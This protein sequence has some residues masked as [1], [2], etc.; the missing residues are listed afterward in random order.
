MAAARQSQADGAAT[1]D[2]PGNLQTPSIAEIARIFPDL[3]IL[4]LIGRGGMGAVYKVRQKNLDRIV[5]LKVFLYRPHDVEF[6][7]RFQREARALA[8]LNHP[9]IVTVHDFGIRENTHFLIMEYVDGLNLRQLTSEERLP[10]EM[11]LQ[12][13]PQL[14]D[15]LQYAHDHG[16]IHR[17]IKPENLLLDARGKI[18]IADFGL[19]KLT[20]NDVNASLTRTQ[21]IMGTYNYMA[22][23]QREHPMEVDNRADIYSLGVVIYEMLTG[24]LPIGRFQPPSSKSSVDARLDEVVMRALEKDPNLRYQQANQFKTGYESVGNFVP[25]QSPVAPVKSS[26]RPNG[27]RCLITVMS[28]QEK[29]GNW[30]PGDPQLAM[31]LWGGT[32]LDLTDV[33]SND[34]NLTLFTTMGATEVIVPHGA[35]VDLDGFILMGATKNNVVAGQGKSNMHVRIR[36]WGAMGGCEIRTPTQKELV[37]QGKIP[38]IVPAPPRKPA[39]SKMTIAGGL[40]MLYKLFAMLVSI[41]IPIVFLMIPF[42]DSFRDMDVIV[43][44]ILVSLIAGFVWSGLD[45][46]RILVGAGPEKDDPKAWQAYES[47]T[48]L[49]TIIRWLGLVFSFACPILIILSVFSRQT[50]IPVYF[51]KDQLMFAGIVSAIIGGLIFAVSD[52]VEEFMYGKH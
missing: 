19:A 6:A 31:T 9:N 18:N 3:E 28:G 39:T 14:C 11:A 41:A 26:V 47:A 25:Q 21:Q 16:V 8:K 4:E 20:G 15:A 48:K 49:G 45:Y 1:M 30:Q 36:S 34:V 27:T 44:G 33:Q 24:E 17:D 37:A 32:V 5:A 29:R 12:M 46:F 2:R 38:A 13:I 52:M 50:L 42:G 51:E 23:E 35:T 43:V 7:A 10:P 40:V 22:P